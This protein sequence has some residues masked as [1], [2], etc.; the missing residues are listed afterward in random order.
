MKV[1]DINGNEYEIQE[2][3]DTGW[4]NLAPGINLRKRNG[5]VTINFQTNVTQVA[6]WQTLAKLPEGCIP[7][8]NIFG[9]ISENQGNPTLQMNLQITTDGNITAICGSTGNCIGSITYPV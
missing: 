4:M 1:Y 7:N 9:V 3:E 5:I 6:N 2:V 8:H